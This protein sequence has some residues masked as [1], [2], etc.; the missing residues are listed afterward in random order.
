MADRINAQNARGGKILGVMRYV[1]GISLVGSI[2]AL[3]VTW[4]V[5]ASG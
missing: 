4:L 2:L 5:Q 3:I 1:L